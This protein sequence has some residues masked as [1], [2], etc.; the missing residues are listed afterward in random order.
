MLGCFLLMGKVGIS[1]V[2]S[3]APP[4]AEMSPPLPD[5]AWLHRKSRTSILQD[6]PAVHL[7]TSF[8]ETT[9]RISIH[10]LRINLLLA[11]Q[12]KAKSA[13][14]ETFQR[15]AKLVQLG[16]ALE[17]QDRIDLVKRNLVFGGEFVR[18]TGGIVRSKVGIQPGQNDM[19]HMST[20]L[21]HNILRHSGDEI[22]P[23]LKKIAGA[24][25]REP[26]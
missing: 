24:E 12:A 16:I 13:F 6:N 21:F 23:Q 7:F 18:R 4:W 1:A 20:A 11:A 14:L 19:P 3:Y 15:C 10:Q 17:C 8:A 25:F 22:Q 9:R 26:Q 2:K 5:S